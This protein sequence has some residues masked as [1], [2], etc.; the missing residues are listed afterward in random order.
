WRARRAAERAQPAIWLPVPHPLRPRPA[1]LRRG[2]A[3]AAPVQSQQAPGRLP[4]SAANPAVTRSRACG[5]RPA[6]VAGAGPQW[7]HRIRIR[8]CVTFIATKLVVSGPSSRGIRLALPAELAIHCRSA[9][10]WPGG[11]S[12]AEASARQGGGQGLPGRFLL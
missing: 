6:A 4:L 12:W 10:G 11:R 7:V 8:L 2:R 5:E 9:V 3:A 1:D